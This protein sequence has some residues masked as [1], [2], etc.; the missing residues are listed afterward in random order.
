MLIVMQPPVYDALCK[1]LP[2]FFGRGTFGEAIDAQDGITVQRPQVKIAILSILLLTAGVGLSAAQGA[3]VTG[4]VRDAQ[5]VAQLGALVQVIAADTA[6]ISTGFTDLHGHYFIPHLTPGRYEVRASA[7]LF[8]PAMRGDLQLS[9]GAQAV[10][11]LT[12]NT[13]FES[14][15]WLPAE[16]RKADEPNDDWKW[17]LRSAANRPILRM[18]DDNGD[19]LMVSS[20]V[21][22]LPRHA[23][24]GQAEITNGDGGFGSNGVHNVVAVDEATADGGTVS[25][26]TDIGNQIGSFAGQ[27]STDVAARYQTN[28]GFAGSARTLVNYQWHPELTASDGTVGLE[29]VQMASAQ[30]MKIGD[31]AEVEA[32][33]TV[34]VVRTAGYSSASR[35]FLKVT[36]H[37]TGTWMVGYRMA[38]SQNLQS[39]GGLDAMQQELPVAV[40]YQG[41][42][43]T[44]GGLHQELSVGRKVG[45]GM[46]QVGYYR[47]RLDRVA[48]SGGG[49]PVAADM[50]QGGVLAANGMM[51]DSTNGT[52]RLLGA[53][54]KT[55]GLHVTLTEPLN[56]S[57]WMAVEYGIGAGLAAKDGVTMM[58]PGM[59][60]DLA[61]E[62]GQTATV[63]LRGR[64]IRSGTKVRVAYRWQPTRI[65]TAVDPYAPFSDDAYFSCYLRQALRLGKLLPHGLDA[66]VDVTNLMAQGYR[67]FLSA[68]GHTLFLAQTPR[69]L[70]A[71]LAFTF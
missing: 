39:F 19:V 35:P 5:G 4:V 24:K 71:G 61:P 14:T 52:F 8:V 30:Q 60:S 7:A 16:R 42:M 40:M 54:Y 44:E 49:A 67:P 29:A 27:P 13:L 26:R 45:Q 38:T 62:D 43:Q 32:G 63:A 28:L 18:V 1:T 48:V 55:Q 47:D 53:G 37:P 69:T 59:A 20:S 56:P 25:F 31:M 58:L 22:E 41:R 34:Y 64:V 2:S 57:I 6:L 66:T 9:S 12:L 23:A 10:V 3:A 33:G 11:N 46:I 51:T 68:D 70:Q 50:T 36:A 65:V 17:T 21:T 15:T